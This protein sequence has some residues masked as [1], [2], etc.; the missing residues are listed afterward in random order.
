MGLCHKASGTYRPSPPDAPEYLI[1]RGG[2]HL[3]R[4]SALVPTSTGGGEG[5]AGVVRFL[6][7]FQHRAL[8]PN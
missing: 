2:T 4:S 3:L 5:T 7:F 8:A 6:G 1:P